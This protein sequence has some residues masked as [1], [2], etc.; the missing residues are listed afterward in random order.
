MQIRIHRH[1]LPSWARIVV[2]TFKH[3]EERRPQRLIQT[4][5]S[6][7]SANWRRASAAVAAAAMVGVLGGTSPAVGQEEVCDVRL[8]IEL[9]PNVPNVG[10]DGFL[11]S[12]LNRHMNYRLALL[13]RDDEDASLVEVELT[14]PGPEYQCQ[15]VIETMRRDA[16]VQSVHIE[17]T[18][19]A[20]RS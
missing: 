11:S 9:D 6:A 3:S 12:L 8:T 5:T 15:N 1:P 4:G 14:G 19:F 7:V 2:A 10:N 13:R 16:R 17:F 18:R 20:S